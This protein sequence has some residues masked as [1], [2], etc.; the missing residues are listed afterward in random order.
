MW[1][2]DPP[3]NR[4]PLIAGS[5]AAVVALAAIV[6]GVLYFT[7]WSK[8]SAPQSDEDQI[9]A[10]V[11]KYEAAWNDETYSDMTSIM[12]KEGLSAGNSDEGSFKRAHESH[13]KVDLT[14]DS[15]KID[16]DNATAVVNDRDSK[17]RSFKFV[18]DDGAWKW[19]GFSD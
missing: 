10:V 12:C 15:V 18:R 13:A 1:L 11:Q 2:P 5:I 17:T 19:C 9:R 7:V 16:G 14:V 4:T 3:K 6:V 8:D